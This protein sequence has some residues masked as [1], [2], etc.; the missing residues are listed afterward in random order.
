MSVATP[1][2]WKS[3]TSSSPAREPRLKQ[4]IKAV[5]HRTSRTTP[6]SGSREDAL[7]FP[8]AHGSKRPMNFPI[9]ANPIRLILKITV[10]TAAPFPAIK[11]LH[12]PFPLPAKNLVL[13]H[14]RIIQRRMLVHQ[15]V[16]PI[17]GQIFRSMTQRSKSV[18]ALKALLM[19]S[20]GINM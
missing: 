5:L 10:I 2:L 1:F 12:A 16:K 4:P 13:P 9:P 17:G 7:S 18:I 8:M 19:V 14:R 3:I 20:K 15:W 11:M 6:P